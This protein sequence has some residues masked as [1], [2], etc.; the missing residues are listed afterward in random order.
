MHNSAVNDSILYVCTYCIVINSI[1]TTGYDI[2]RNYRMCLQELHDGNYTVS[3]LSLSPTLRDHRR[4]LTCRAHNSHSHSHSPDPDL[5]YEHSVTLN[6][7]C[8]YHSQTHSK[9]L[10]N[11]EVSIG[12]F[13]ACMCSTVSIGCRYSRTQTRT[14][15]YSQNT[16]SE[17]NYETMRSRASYLNKYSCRSLFEFYR[18]SIVCIR[19]C[20]PLVRIEISASALPIII[21]Y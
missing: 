5:L 17:S 21:S 13:N 7:G 20:L 8:K 1:R 14:S 12:S 16:H 9:L 3:S 2:V 18:T 15:R 6:V 10:N 11:S 4:L 19:I